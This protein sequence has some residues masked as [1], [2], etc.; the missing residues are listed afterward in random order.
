MYYV[1]EQ[2]ETVP[3]SD[4]EDE[5][6]GAW[7]WLQETLAGRVALVGL[8]VVAGGDDSVYLTVYDRVCEGVRV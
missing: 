1:D 7:E 5:K 4:D 8:V 3:V 2:G 6:V